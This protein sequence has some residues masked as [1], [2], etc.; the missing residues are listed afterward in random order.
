MPRLVFPPKARALG[1]LPFQA[2]TAVQTCLLLRAETVLR[3]SEMGVWCG[4]APGSEAPGMLALSPSQGQGLSCPRGGD[5][6]AVPGAA[7]GPGMYL[8]GPVTTSSLS[9]LARSYKI[10]FNSISCSDPLVSSWRRKRKESSNTDSA[11]A[12]GTLRSGPHQEGCNGWAS[13]LGKRGLQKE[14]Q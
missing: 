8:Q 14:L 3:S 6:E 1:C 12:L 11:G 10:R 9:S 13:C 2:G 5:P 7:P 4:R